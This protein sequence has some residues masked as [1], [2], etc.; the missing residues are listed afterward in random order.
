M[1]EL[2]LLVYIHTQEDVFFYPPP[3]SARPEGTIFVWDDKLHFI[4]HV[5]RCEKEKMVCDGI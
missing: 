2:S 3:T 1:A 5:A 4:C